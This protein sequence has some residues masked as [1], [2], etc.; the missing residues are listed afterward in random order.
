M[1]VPVGDRCEL[2]FKGHD[3]ARFAY[4]GRMNS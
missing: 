2:R 1:A 3:G 4:A